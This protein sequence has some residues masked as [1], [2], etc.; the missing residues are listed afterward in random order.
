MKSLLVGTAIA[1]VGLLISAPATAVTLDLS[2]ADL[3]GGAKATMIN[4]LHMTLPPSF[5]Q[6]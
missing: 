4:Q 2:K 5:I 6:F 3:A 1:L